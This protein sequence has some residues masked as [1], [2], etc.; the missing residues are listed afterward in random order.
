METMTLSAGR[1][2]NSNHELL[3]LIAIYMIVFI[4]ANMYLGT[5]CTGKYF[6]F[7]NGLVNGL[8]NIGVSCF[9]LISGYYGVRC[10]IRKLV[11]MECMM[12]T[13]SLAE[14]AVLYAVFPDRMRG[15]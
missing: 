13:L 2:R 14:T 3:R 10:D 5:F 4:H 6:V 9:I 12:I 7:F 8:C 11:R 15:G 1:E